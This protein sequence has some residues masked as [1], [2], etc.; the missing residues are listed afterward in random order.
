MFDDL[1]RDWEA[2][3]RGEYRIGP[4]KTGR[5]Y[6][7]LGSGPLNTAASALLRFTTELKV[8]RANGSVERYRVGS[9]GDLIPIKDSLWQTFTRTLAKI[10]LRICSMAQSLRQRITT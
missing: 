8:T 1:R 7:K 6:A 5:I 4:A 3:K 2:A 9:A 10:L